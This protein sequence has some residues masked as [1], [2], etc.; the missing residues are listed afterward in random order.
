MQ[1]D[2][3][4]GGSGSICVEH[5][6]DYSCIWGDADGNIPNYCFDC[7]GMDGSDDCPSGCYNDNGQCDPSGLNCGPD[8]DYVV[9]STAYSG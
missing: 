6:Q 4:P 3:P 1:F 2:F 9:T 8:D 5:S 7:E